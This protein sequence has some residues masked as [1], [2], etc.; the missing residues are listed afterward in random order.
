MAR[1]RKKTTLEYAS[2]YPIVQKGLNL[3]LQ[4]LGIPKENVT[5]FNKGGMG[6]LFLANYNGTKKLIKIPSYYTRTPDEYW[7]S[8]HGIKKEGE[9]LSEINCQLIPE[10]LHLDSN[11]NFLV[12]EYFEGITLSKIDNHT[13]QKNKKQLILSLINTAKI[14]L[15]HIHTHPKGNFVIR[16]FKPKNLILPFPCSKQ[17]YLIDLGSLRPEQ[18][19]TSTSFSKNDKIGSGKWLYWAPE[20]LIESKKYLSRKADYFSFGATAFHILTGRPPY[21]NSISDP[22]LFFNRYLC[23]YNEVIKKIY[24]FSR[25]INLSQKV[26]DL[27]IQSLHPKVSYREFNTE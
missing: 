26:I 3:A 8:R 9:I 11:G 7:L 18:N 2:N 21:S 5:P 17:M 1:I 24:Y 23:E 16:D 25:K 22:N 10:L 27:I 12:R 6:V 13:V 19:M 20:Q 15:N 4:V 14:V